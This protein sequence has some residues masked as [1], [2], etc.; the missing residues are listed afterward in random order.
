M[1]LP[2]PVGLR[3]C[4]G[5]EPEE[6]AELVDSVANHPHRT[7][8]PVAWR[9]R[10]TSVCDQL[11]G[12]AEVTISWSDGTTTKTGTT[13]VADVPGVNGFPELPTST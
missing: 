6:C 3:E 11:K 1:D 4:I 2:L 10:C 9:V 8:D 5:V 13:W 7:A 12:D